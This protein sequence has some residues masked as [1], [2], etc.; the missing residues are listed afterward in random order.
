MSIL[1]VNTIQDKGGN[2]IISS[3]GSGNLTQSFA[4]NTPC[5]YGSK[6][7]VQNLARAT[8]TKINN[9]TN[10]EIDTDNAFDGTTFTVPSGKGGKYFIYFKLWADYTT[11]AGSDGE[12]QI[13][14]IYINGSRKQEGDSLLNLAGTANMNGATQTAILTTTLSAGDTVEAYAYIKDENGGQGDAYSNQ[15]IFGGYRLIG[16]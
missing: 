12:Y 1:K 16:A 11:T 15:T 3:D 7:D 4:S 10:N 14:S 13:A 9:F 6:S 8:F 5:F 2:T